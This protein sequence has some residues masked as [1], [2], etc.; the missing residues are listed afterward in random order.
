MPRRSQFCSALVYG[1]AV[2][3]LAYVWGAPENTALRPGFMDDT[4]AGYHMAVNT[5]VQNP[6]LRTAHAGQ[7]RVLIVNPVRSALPL[8]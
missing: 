2:A 5:S 6:E 4:L 1:L 8:F 3:A 7:Y